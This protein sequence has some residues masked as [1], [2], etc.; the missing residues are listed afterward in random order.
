MDMI[1]SW[2]SRRLSSHVCQMSNMNVAAALP[3]S[4]CAAETK[5]FGTGSGAS[6]IAMITKFATGPEV[7]T[8]AAICHDYAHPG[9][10]ND[11]LIKSRHE[12]AIFYNVSSRPDL[13]GLL[14][15][16]AAFPMCLLCSRFLCDGWPFQWISCRTDLR[17][18]I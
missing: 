1:D 7:C 9:V 17:T 14:T 6:L 13:L 3:C 12:L 18:A 2:T 8:L 4:A 11:F 15:E 10:T 5:S 16:D